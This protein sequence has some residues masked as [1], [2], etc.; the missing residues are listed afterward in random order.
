MCKN[1]F[2]VLD[3][4]QL[5]ANFNL[6]KRPKE[7]DVSGFTDHNTPFNALCA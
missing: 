3:A 6:V 2:H 4:V 5:L 7:M 1:I